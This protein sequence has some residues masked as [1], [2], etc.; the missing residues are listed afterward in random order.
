V[1]KLGVVNCEISYADGRRNK[2]DLVDQL[3]PG[4]AMRPRGEPDEYSGKKPTE[5][6]ER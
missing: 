5:Q 3:V 1:H 6:A 4:Y 2:L